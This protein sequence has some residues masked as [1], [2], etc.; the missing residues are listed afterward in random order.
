MTRPA[1]R[2]EEDRPARRSFLALGVVVVALALIGDEFPFSDFPMYSNFDSEVRVVYLA[3]QK[4]EPLPCQRVAG[5]ASSQVKK[6]YK[7]ARRKLGGPREDNGDP[8]LRRNAGAM[9]LE[10]LIQRIRDPEK[11]HRLEWLRENRPDCAG[12][13]LVEIIIR[14]EGSAI[15]EEERVLAEAP[16]VLP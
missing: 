8:H 7:A 6:R 14:R 5:T 1:A 10:D 3:D 13:Q 12:L 2:D 9:V 15:T 16:F 4:G 11:P